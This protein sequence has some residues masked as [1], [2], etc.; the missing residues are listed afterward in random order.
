MKSFMAVFAI[1]TI[2]L[3]TPAGFSAEMKPPEKEIPLKQYRLSVSSDTSGEEVEFEGVI[4]TRSEKDPLKI[5]KE[6][7]PYEITVKTLKSVIVMLAAKSGRIR[8]ELFLIENGKPKEVGYVT[9]SGA[10][11]SDNCGP[12]LH[13]SASAGW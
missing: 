3:T 1:I 6:K 11:I 9:G 10:F 5:L 12:A 7:T 8:T 2:V 4:A 13:D